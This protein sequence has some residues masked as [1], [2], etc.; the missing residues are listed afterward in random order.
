MDALNLQLVTFNVGEFLPGSETDIARLI[1]KPTPGVYFRA[2]WGHSELYMCLCV[3]IEIYTDVF[4]NKQYLSM[5]YQCY[6]P[7]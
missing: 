7:Y 6:I 3:N 1:R 4:V 2:G 5:F